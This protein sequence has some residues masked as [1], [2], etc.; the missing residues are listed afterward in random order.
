ME[1][2]RPR[3]VHSFFF[4][5]LFLL[6][7]TSVPASMAAASNAMTATISH[8]M[9]ALLPPVVAVTDCDAV[10]LP[11]ELLATTENVYV[12]PSVRLL[13]VKVVELVV[14]HATPFT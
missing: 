2:I 6:T 10:P 11:T 8:T 1:A 7:K 4:P 9:L 14:A 5:G 13:S 12:R 3:Y